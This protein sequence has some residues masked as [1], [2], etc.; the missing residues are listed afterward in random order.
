MSEE[1]KN[2]IMEEKEVLN[3]TDDFDEE[4]DEEEE[5]SEDEKHINVEY[6]TDDF[7][8]VLK[9]VGGIPVSAAAAKI[10][11]E[12]AQKTRSEYVRERLAANKDRE[13]RRQE[14]EIFLTGWGALETAMR[15]SKILSAMI[16]G[17]ETKRETGQVLMTMII[18]GRYKAV[19][20]FREFYRD[21]P[22][23]E[24]TIEPR[25]RN[26]RVNRERRF[27][28][29]QKG[30]TV[31]FVVTNMDLNRD[32]FTDHAII[33]SR[34]KA[35]AILEKINYE[36]QRD[37]HTNI[38]EDEIYES[39]IISIGDHGLWVNLAGIDC[40]MELRD[41]TFRYVYDLERIY[42]PGSKLRVKVEKITRDDDGNH[43]VQ[44]NAKAAELESAKEKEYLLAIGTE[45][46]MV[47]TAV[48][49]KKTILF[50]GWLPYYEMPAI[51]SYVPAEA[52]EDRTL[53]GYTA[54]VQVVRF[55][56]NGMVICICTGLEKTTNFERKL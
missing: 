10:E 2:E 34:K 18:E 19:I 56:E 25:G 26:S 49:F 3:T 8:E 50:L 24:N 22:I 36:P 37:G 40:H 33:C 31:P 6:T 54:R 48:N 5:E 9:E 4:D 16:T 41:I 42:T 29:K 55:G 47:I 45:T 20:P 39:T 38:E 21:Y 51:A 28:K 27:A 35:L 17:V 12:K 43:Y 11:T 1:Q 52:L 30:Q 23:D 44:L 7:R 15:N 46:D 53:S 13:K 32:D 14:R